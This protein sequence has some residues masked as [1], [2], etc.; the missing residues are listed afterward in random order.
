MSRRLSGGYVWH[1]QLDNA[2]VAQHDAVKH[3]DALRR[4][5]SSGFVTGHLLDI[6]LALAAIQQAL[7]ELRNVDGR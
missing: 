2:Q 3:I 5:T 6:A 1:E 7:T 4:L